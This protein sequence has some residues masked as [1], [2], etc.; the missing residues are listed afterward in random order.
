[1]PPPHIP[2]L[3]IGFIGPVMTRTVA[4]FASLA[5]SATAAMADDTEGSIFQQEFS[6]I[7]SGLNEIILNAGSQNPASLET[8]S[9]I[10]TAAPLV[11]GNVDQLI[12]NALNVLVSKGSVV[13]NATQISTGS[14]YA[15]N[16]MDGRN[17]T[18]ADGTL[19]QMG[20]NLANV[21]TAEQV[22]SVTQQFGPGA[23]QDVT[24]TALLRG[25]AGS[26][27]QI[28]RNTANIVE[29]EL[30]IG[31]G[32]QVFPFDSTQQINNFVRISDAAPLPAEMA[33][34]DVPA[35]TLIRMSSDAS[36]WQE[37]TN[38]GNILI[39]DEVRDVARV[40]NGQQI[41]NNH[42]ILDDI[43]QAPPQ[44]TQSG[45]NVA[46]F[47][48]ASRV[49]GLTQVSDGVQI[50]ENRVTDGSLADLTAQVPQYT[51]VAENYVNVLHIRAP[52]NPSGGTLTVL[53]ATVSASQEARIP[54][55]S[56][57]GNGRQ[58]QVGNAATVER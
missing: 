8:E 32:S 49:S 57:S 44:I 54:Q 7:Q 14:Q 37:G 43:G 30:S 56:V 26:V 27:V 41:I 36:I 39:A 53:D 22:D 58:V 3:F 33:G 28:G 20:E 48:S 51:H 40:F 35:T 31:L 25:N 29:A 24:N 50:V 45:I 2:D 6:G 23:M 42:I 9:D 16:L 55:S 1:M 47:V 19:R 46:N 15:T 10:G 52:G 11:G 38:M 13:S 4:I 17:A 5:L 34:F 12:T 18:L 21:I